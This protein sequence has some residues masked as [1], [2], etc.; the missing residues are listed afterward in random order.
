MATTDLQ[1]RFLGAQDVAAIVTQA[2]LAAALRGLAPAWP[3]IR[4][5]A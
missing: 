4:P 3:A 2:G 1:T 5:T